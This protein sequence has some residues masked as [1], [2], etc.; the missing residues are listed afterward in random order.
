MPVR[1][2]TTGLPQPGHHDNGGGLQRQPGWAGV[3]EVLLHMNRSIQSDKR[4]KS[5]DT[6]MD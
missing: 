6:G 3:W 5:T 4:N 2:N 1:I